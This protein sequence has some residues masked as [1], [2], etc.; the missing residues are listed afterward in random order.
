MP[1][2]T[3][4][5]WLIVLFY[6]AYVLGVGFIFKSTIKTARDF[7]GASR[8]LP[9]WICGLA[10]VSISLGAPELIGIGGFGARYGLQAAQFFGIGAIPA[11]VFAGIFI[12]PLYYGSKSRTVPEFL[13]L[14]FDQK[15][16][17][18]S[19]CLFLVMTVFSAGLAMYAVAHVVQALHLFDRYLNPIGLHAP[20]IFTLTI[21]LL[22]LFVLVYVLLGGLSAAI[23][24][25]VAQFLLIVAGLLPVVILGLKNIGGWAGLKASLPP[26]NLHQWK[27]VLHPGTNLMGIE[28]VGICLGLGIV[29]AAG[30]WCTNFVV[31]QAA[32]A[33]R[34]MNSAR[35]VPLIAAF[36]RMLLPF[37]VVL[38]GM[39]A[40]AVPTPHSITSVTTNADGS[41]IHNIQIVPPEIEQGK[42]IVPAQLDATG[43]PV[44]AST[45]KPLL[46]YDMALPNLLLHYLPVGVLGL[47]LTALLASFMTGLAG[48][49][50]AF[51]AIFTCDVYQ[52]C[53]HKNGTDRHYLLVA[54][55]A[56]VG[57]ILLSIAAA[58]GAA[59]FG[60]I[61]D[62]LILLLSLLSAP[63][64]ATY[65]LGMFWKRATGHGAFAGMVAGTIA[66]V[67]HHGLTLPAAA[68]RGM[69]G[70]WINVLHQYPSAMEQGFWTAILAFSANAL[71]AITVSLL[72][73]PKP[74]SELKGLVY[75]LTPKPPQAP[76][77]WWHRPETLGIAVLIAALVLNILFA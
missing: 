46:D 17:I 28:I 5:D 32:L 38:P 40:V 62:L 25:Q 14:R 55:L 50:T 45:G 48:H 34:D 18:L 68:H 39:L 16:R 49:M 59:Q 6:L 56:T 1:K 52:S 64:L 70:G 15:T 13:R 30:Y 20:G 63:A 69:H 44:V 43:H 77:P 42:G 72:T 10:C 51:N 67:L 74:E 57:G 27:G 61:L 24:N 8:V 26:A 9:A 37:L 47:G 4:V 58:Y 60:G 2:L 7:F 3:H 21:A 71:I 65:L 23:Y 54:R 36:P 41:I 33:A 35:N 12:V 19:A 53:L 29:L 66:A 75:S 11:M 31:L 76:G 73:N 22:S